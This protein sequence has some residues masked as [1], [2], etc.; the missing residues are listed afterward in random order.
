LTW[1]LGD[2]GDV[3]TALRMAGAL[4]WFWLTRAHATEGRQWLETV[5]ERPGGAPESYFKVCHGAGWLAHIQHDATAAHSPADAALRIAQELGD[6]RALSWALTLRARISYFAGDA[7]TVRRLADQSLTAAHEAGDEWLTA[8]ALHIHALAAHISADYSGARVY[9]EQSLAIRQRLG[10][11]EGIGMCHM[12]IGMVAYSEGAYEAALGPSRESLRILRQVGQHIVHNALATF[13]GLAARLG[14]PHRAA[15]LAGAIA[16]YRDLINVTPIP[17]AQEIVTQVP[18]LTQQAIGS[19]DFDQAWAEGQS[20]SIDEAIEEALS[21]EAPSL[22]T[23]RPVDLPAARPTPPAGLSPREV[24]VLCL[25]AAGQTSK[26][27]AETLVLS[28]RTVER[29]ITHVY[30]KIGA[31]GRA[32]A[33]AF[34]LKHGLR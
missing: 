12:L 30:E 9:Y 10:H 15:R 16:A 6:P 25:I 13:A 27:V 5:R 24:E 31:R 33:A 29:H 22:P 34:A 8:W 4:V 2:G 17:L 19:A 18:A 1:S 20:L 3:D 14:Q 11:L 23:E 21:V 26:E 7:A 32:D 28:V